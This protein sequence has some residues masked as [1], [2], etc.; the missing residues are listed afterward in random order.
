MMHIFKY[1]ILCFIKHKDLMF[2]TLVFPICL[3]TLFFF[4]F[5]KLDDAGNLE[6]IDVAIVSDQN[7]GFNALI[8]ELSQGD[9]HIINPVYVS[10]SE[11]DK[12][13]ED[14]EI[15]AILISESTPSI[16]FNAE[17]IQVQVLKEV[18]QSYMAKDATISDLMTYS[19]INQEII[20]KVFTNNVQ[21]VDQGSKA[22]NAKLSSQYFFTVIAMM[23]LYSGFWGIKIM[24][25]TQANQSPQAL[26]LNVTPTHKLKVILVDF[27]IA[28]ILML[29]E[30]TLVI[31]YL[32]KVLKVDFGENL[33]LT[34]LVVV[35]GV[36]ASLSMG[37]LLGASSKLQRVS[38]VNIYN[39][40]SLL[41]CFLAGMMMVQIPYIIDKN[42]AFVKYINPATLITNSFNVLYYYDDMSVVYTNI[43]ILLLLGAVLLAASYSLLRRK[44]YASV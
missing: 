24:A 14:E 40:I 44:S 15:E 32:M 41:S 3:A 4:A 29:L 36:I 39:T 27:I 7:E 5:G 31:I 30:V 20:N 16:I 34:G 13:L 9:N 43:T 6:P 25:E 18:V 26:R 21:V 1:R 38:N 23:I 8:D 19:E 11:A 35:S 10:E 28:L 33:I 17:S 37:I 2:W 12:L 22:V 42:F